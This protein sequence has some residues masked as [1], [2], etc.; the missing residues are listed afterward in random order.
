MIEDYGGGP[1][2]TGMRVLITQNRDKEHGVVNG[3]PATMMFY[4]NASVFL[5]H[6]KGYICCIYPVTQRD[7]NG[8]NYTVYPMTPAYASTITKVQ[9][10]N[11][12]K[13]IVWLD[14]PTV[15]NGGAYVA[16]SRIRKHDN[17]LFMKETH[18]SQYNPVQLDN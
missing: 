14:C 15:P 11:M 8:K 12:K 13:I 10:Q 6:P 4:V 7:E 3:Q 18:P 2:Y 9:G 16:L 5:K 17:L 1:L